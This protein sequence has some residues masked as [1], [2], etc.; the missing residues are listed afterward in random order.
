MSVIIGPVWSLSVRS[1]EEDDTRL[2]IG[3]G[4]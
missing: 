4:S 2:L 3:R 1:Y